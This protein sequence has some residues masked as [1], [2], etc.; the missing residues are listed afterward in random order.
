[1]TKPRFS[2]QLAALIVLLLPISLQMTARDS[3]ANQATKA[4]QGL[5]DT[6]WDYTMEQNPTW[7][8]Q[9]GDRRWNDRW[10]DASLAAIEQRHGHASDVLARLKKIDRRKL[11]PKDQLNYDLFQKHYETA[12]EEHAY[13]WYL[14]PLNQREGIQTADELADALRFETVKD[15][16]DWI[17]RLRSFPVYLDQ[18]IALMR[19]GIRERI[20]QSKIVMDQMAIIGQPYVL[21]MRTSLLGE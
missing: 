11:S 6:E 3:S 2:S 17:A 4:L 16:E 13:H 1:M 20:V 15:Y 5:F 10:E 7:A 8:S 12:T 14:A 19:E 18:T 9:L 21:Q